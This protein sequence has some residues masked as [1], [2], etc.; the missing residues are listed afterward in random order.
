VS[1]GVRLPRLTR[2]ELAAIGDRPILVDAEDQAWWD[3]LDSGQ[4]GGHDHGTAWADGS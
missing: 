1:D 3:G 2:E 4:S